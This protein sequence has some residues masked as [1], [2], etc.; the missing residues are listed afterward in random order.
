MRSLH[1]SP[2]SAVAR[3]A[4]LAT[5]AGCSSTAAAPSD[6]G[7]TADAGATDG[8]QSPTDEG[9]AGDGGPAA[10]IRGLRYCEILLVTLNANGAHVDVYS[11][12]GLN[13]CPE[14]T[15]SAVDATKVAAEQ[16]V[17][18]AVLNGPRYWTLDH[19]VNASL[20]DPTPRTVGGLPMRHAG[21]IDVPT[22][23]L[24]AF[25]ATPYAPNTVQ[26]TTTVQLDAGKSV[27]ELV[28]P[29]GKIYD[30]QSYSV[31][32]TAQTEADLATLGA[33][34]TLPA[35]WTYR[36]RTLTANLQITAL[37]G[38][39]TVLQDDFANTYQLSQQ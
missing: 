17:S 35:G 3:A 23:A 14:A 18:K 30:M 22:A 29:D 21:S 34:L 37:G 12:F 1:F 26:R 28:G 25:A 20:V 16:A 19:F 4:L 5:L 36:T 27:Y 7:T 2:P 9:G 13:D 8:A 10:E 15:W 38:L 11:T 32:K 39:A 24:G 31:Q 6:G 33:R